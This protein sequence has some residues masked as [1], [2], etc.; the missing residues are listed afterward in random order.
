[1]NLSALPGWRRGFVEACLALVGAEG[2]DWY[3]GFC[4]R[5]TAEIAPQAA[6]VDASGSYPRD[7]VAVLRE[8]GVFGA[9]LPV[10]Q[11]GLGFGPSIASLAVETVAAACPST[12][13]VLM[14]H[15]QVI[16]RLVRF[17]SP[18]QQEETL[19]RLVRGEWM[20]ASAW[21]E[22][23]SGAD[24]SRL[25]TRLHQGPQGW[26]LDGAKTYCTGLEGAQVVHALV[27]V[28]DAAGAPVPS[29]IQVTTDTP[30]VAIEEIYPLLGMRGSSTGTIRF[31]DVVATP[32]DLV[33]EVGGG[34]RMMANSHEVCVNPGLLA[35][36][37]AAASYSELL[38]SVTGANGSMVDSTGF[39]HT[40]LT[41]AGL[42][43]QLGSAYAYAAQAVR[44]AASD[45]TQK[46]LECLRSKVQASET[47]TALTSGAMQLVGSR[48][49]RSGHPLERHFRD[50][51]ATSLMGPCTEV[52]KEQVAASILEQARRGV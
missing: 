5:V 27:A 38:A 33:G 9:A 30:G 31:D 35:L 3:Q 18:R 36:G 50:A 14:F 2:S 20:G 7:G 41:L 46:N 43:M 21:T 1:V 11:G 19:P 44:Y 42:E 12:A 8:S 6:H 13:A 39:Q 29:F 37:I 52:V 51:R 15:L 17:G 10:A 22:A 48:A 23:S 47:A 32:A 34:R 25:T 24:K 16:L 45:I 49:F 40:R 26:R 28:P 4:K